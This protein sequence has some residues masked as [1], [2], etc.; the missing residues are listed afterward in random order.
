MFWSDGVGVQF[1][2]SMYLLNTF[3]CLWL[4]VFVYICICGVFSMFFAVPC[5]PCAITLLRVPFVT[6]IGK[7]YCASSAEHM[8]VKIAFPACFLIL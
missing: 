7:D 8:L 5:C 4:T 1:Q 3:V 6:R 2:Y